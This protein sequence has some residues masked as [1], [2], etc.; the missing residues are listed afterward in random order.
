MK[1]FVTGSTGLLG[2]NLINTLLAQ[3]YEVKALAR[4]IDKA[5]KLLTDQHIQ[6][7][8]GDM[9]DVNS[10]APEIADCDVVFHVAAYF[11]EY[12]NVG[13][14]W[15][16]L[17]QINVK[18]TLQILDAAEKY[19]VK[20]VIYV[21]SGGVIGEYP[22]GRAGD[23]NA[24]VSPYAEQNLYFKSKVIAE[25]AVE[26]WLRTHQTP[27][28][29]I[30]PTAMLAPQDSAPTTLGQAMVDIMHRKYPFIPSGG[31]E[32]V[33][34]RD[35]AQAMVNAVE[36]GKSG[37]RYIISEGYHTMAEFVTAIGKASGVPIPRMIASK[38][39]L[40]VIAN[41][42]EL[43]AN[44][45]GGDVQLSRSA[46]ETMNKKILVSSAKAKRELG[47]KFRPFEDTIRDEVNWFIANGYVKS[48][49]VVN[50]PHPATA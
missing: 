39:M 30:L 21:S 9:E 36:R 27:V 14:H 11:R 42:S 40:M 44:L 8:K 12:Y 50:P 16:K 32:L 28:V 19:G 49:K 41:L 6:I 47:V 18:G 31:F 15:T 24:P 33:D 4:S 23:E 46:V 45:F 48:A 35:V 25:K 29:M 22:D 37:E 3:G 2:S 38:N 5:R 17:E 43:R 26:D 13:D 34:A 7:V 10:F 1:A 20:K